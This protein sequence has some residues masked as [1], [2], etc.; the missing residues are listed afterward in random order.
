MDTPSSSRLGC[1]NLQDFN[2]PFHTTCGPEREVNKTSK[3][4]QST[5]KY[6]NRRQEWCWETSNFGKGRVQTKLYPADL[7]CPAYLDY[8]LLCRWNPKDQLGGRG[9]LGRGSA[10]REHPLLFGGPG[11][12]IYARGNRVGAFNLGSVHSFAPSHIIGITSVAPCGGRVVRRRFDFE[13]WGLNI[14]D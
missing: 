12:P 5:T 4:K 10:N 13:G 2:L 3:G 8:L 6:K 1:R 7:T 14:A 9:W 11:R